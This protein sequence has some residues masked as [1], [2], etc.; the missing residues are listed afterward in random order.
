[1]KDAISVF[2]RIASAG[3]G[4]KAWRCVASAAQNTKAFPG[5]V[6]NTLGLRETLLTYLLEFPTD[7]FLQV[8]KLIMD[9]RQY[10]L[11]P[12]L[13]ELLENC[14][15]EK[16]VQFLKEGRQKAGAPLIRHYCTLA[17]YRLQEEGPYESDLIEWAKQEANH[18][19]I[20]FREEDSSS[21]W[22]PGYQLTP[23]ETSHFLIT[24]FETLAKSQNQVGIETL[25]HAIA[26]GHP[27]NRYALAGLLMRTT[28]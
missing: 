7:D 25:I 12:L 4:L 5:I 10:E 6:E 1:M 8:A 3:R 27:K 20:R 17:L 14:E 26:H 18:P 28:E 19:I 23:E 2:Y 22:N 11:F 13:V 16:T 15:G 9:R 24:V 21:Q